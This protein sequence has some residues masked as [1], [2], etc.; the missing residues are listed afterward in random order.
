[1]HSSYVLVKVYGIDIFI[2]THRCILQHLHSSTAKIL[3]G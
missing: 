3:G 2:F 1:M